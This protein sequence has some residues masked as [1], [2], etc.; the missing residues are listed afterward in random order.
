M[1]PSLKLAFYAMFISFV[2]MN[3]LQ[4]ADPKNILEDVKDTHVKT[5]LKVDEEKQ[6]KDSQPKDATFDTKEILGT[7]AKAAYK[8]FSSEELKKVASR[9][10]Q[11]IKNDFEEI[12]AQGKGF[13]SKVFA[14]VKN[15][16]TGIVE[17]V[18]PLVK[19]VIKEIA[20]VL[21]KTAAT[22]AVQA[23]ITAI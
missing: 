20:P 22:F 1:K 7:A 17:Y 10:H 13:F 4:A 3:A 16:A 14:V 5:M 8:N 12:K 9:T 11:N 23:L 6:T 15:V 19:N 21:I 2:T 18:G